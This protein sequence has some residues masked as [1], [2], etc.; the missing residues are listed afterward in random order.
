M[1][2]LDLRG[3]AR[4]CRRSQASA[5]IWG[6]EPL[7]AEEIQP[8][9]LRAASTSSPQSRPFGRSGCSHA[10]TKLFSSA[11]CHIQPHLAKLCDQTS[12]PVIYVLLFY[13]LAHAVHAHLL[14]FRLHLQGSADGFC[15][16]I[17][18]VRVHQQSIPQFTRGSGEL[19]QDQYA[20]FVAPGGKKFLGHQVHAVVQ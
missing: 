10:A 6:P 20:A 9:V 4:A 7:P 8:W 3:T 1:P 11:T 12:R 19:A 15:S 13:G 5:A 14:L 18:V 2:V 17:N 16:L